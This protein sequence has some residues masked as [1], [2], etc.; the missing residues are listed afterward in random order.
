MK[1]RETKLKKKK[2]ILPEYLA[3]ASIMS[4]KEVCKDAS[5]NWQW[6]WLLLTVNLLK[7]E[8]ELRG[9]KQRAVR[10]FQNMQ[11]ILNFAGIF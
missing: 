5:F 10:G 3:R 7:L 1:N 11:C 8:D 2:K 4:F 9:K 6:C